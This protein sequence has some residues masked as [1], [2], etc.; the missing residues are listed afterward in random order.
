[1][2]AQTTMPQTKVTI[3]I[4]L[5]NKRIGINESYESTIL[6]NHTIIFFSPHIQYTHNFNK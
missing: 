6:K 3:K 1:M 2:Q 4:E 5:N